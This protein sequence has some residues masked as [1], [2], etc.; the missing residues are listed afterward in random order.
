[1]QLNALFETVADSWATILSV[2]NTNILKWKWLSPK[3]TG[4]IATYIQNHEAMSQTS[5]SG[6]AIKDRRDWPPQPHYIELL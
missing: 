5:H 2:L 3:V 6:K 4:F 1:M